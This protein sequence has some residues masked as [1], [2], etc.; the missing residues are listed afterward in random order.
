MVLIKIEESKIYLERNLTHIYIETLVCIIDL[1]LN[2][3]WRII[4]ILLII[5]KLLLKKNKIPLMKKLYKWYI[6][7][8]MNLKILKSKA[9]N[10]LI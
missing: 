7:K 2:M 5:S 10:T 6:S 9:M 1:Y 4:K 3:T 8:K